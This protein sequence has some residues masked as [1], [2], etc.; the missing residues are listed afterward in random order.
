[1]RWCL[2]QNEREINE[3]NG[4]ISRSLASVTAKR[5]HAYHSS[6]IKA[7]YHCSLM[8]NLFFRFYYHYVNSLISFL[9]CFRD[10]ITSL[11][12]KYFSFD[13]DVD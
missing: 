9:F 6:L 10:N 13:A 7:P 11:M 5:G 4:R 1:M 2:S 8:K 3:R 12:K